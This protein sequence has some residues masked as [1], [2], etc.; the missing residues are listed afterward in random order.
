MKLFCFYGNLR[1]FRNV[2]PRFKEIGFSKVELEVFEW[3]FWE[4]FVHKML[5]CQGRNPNYSWRVGTIGC[6]MK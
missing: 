1:K 5:H 3:R 6:K 2:Q 4:E